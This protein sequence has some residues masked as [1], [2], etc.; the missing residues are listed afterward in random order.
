MYCLQLKKDVLC[1]NA[2]FDGSS[3]K[4]SISD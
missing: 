4:E 3:D 1:T 2:R